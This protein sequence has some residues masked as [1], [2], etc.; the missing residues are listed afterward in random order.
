MQERFLGG[1]ARCVGICLAKSS[2]PN[3]RVSTIGN[4]A[5]RKAEERRTSNVEHRTSNRKNRSGLLILRSMLGARHGGARPG[6]RRVRCWA[7]ICWFPLPRMEKTIGIA[8][9]F[10]AY[11]QR[12]HEKRST[13]KS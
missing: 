10:C 2:T 1:T 7:F 6:R 4:R 13:Y 8:V 12:L 11:I 3:R 9:Q 5:R